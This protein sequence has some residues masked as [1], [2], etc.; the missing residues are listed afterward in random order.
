MLIQDN[1]WNRGCSSPLQATWNYNKF[2]QRNC[3]K[4][5]G[6]VLPSS[7][8]RKLKFLQKIR[9]MQMEFSALP[10]GMGKVLWVPKALSC[11]HEWANP[12]RS[13]Y[14]PQQS[15]NSK[16][17]LHPQHHSISSAPSH[18]HTPPAPSLKDQ[19]ALK[20]I[21]RHKYHLLIYHFLPHLSLLSWQ[22]A[23]IHNLNFNTKL[24]EHCV[25]GTLK[26][27]DFSFSFR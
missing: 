10:S 27:A 17:S 15:S 19:T 1:C 25:N 16:H 4:E 13:Q 12:W 2:H 3:I 6:S 14:W 22:S 5:V 23:V 8:N 24:Q 21:W 20:W 9:I 26:N 11:A 18:Q 7:T